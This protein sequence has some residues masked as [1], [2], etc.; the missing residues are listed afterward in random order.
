M[1]WRRRPRDSHP[2]RSRFFVIGL[3]DGYDYAEGEVEVGG[4]G[5]E[6]DQVTHRGRV[7]G[8]E[9]GVMKLKE[10]GLFENQ[11]FLE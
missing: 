5:P 11:E 9:L 1:C 4:H 8:G 10:L 6:V 7:V 2:I 3:L